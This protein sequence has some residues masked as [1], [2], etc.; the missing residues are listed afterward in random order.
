MEKIT[1]V[2]K[3]ETK[4][5]KIENFYSSVNTV[6]YAKIR[7]HKHLLFPS[8]YKYMNRHCPIKGK[9]VHYK[10]NY[11]VDQKVS[12]T[13]HHYTNKSLKVNK[14]TKRFYIEHSGTTSTSAK[15]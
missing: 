11:D 9:D 7:S 6:S 3:P 12:H 15:W 1:T 4:T 13:I 5:F 10:L 8:S 2:L 14:N